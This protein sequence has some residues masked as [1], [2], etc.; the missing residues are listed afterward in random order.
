[1]SH[2]AELASE[3]CK[4]RSITDRGS[5]RRFAMVPLVALGYRAVQDVR[6][7]VPL[8]ESSTVKS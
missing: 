3:S 4:S 7:E 6:E 8:T 5:S 1:M 2:R